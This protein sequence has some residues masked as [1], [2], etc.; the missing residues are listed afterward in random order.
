MHELAMHSLTAGM[1]MCDL[2]ASSTYIIYVA[3]YCC[4]YVAI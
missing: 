4:Y 3:R 2:Q 1:H